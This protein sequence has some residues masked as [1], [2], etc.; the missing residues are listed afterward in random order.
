MPLSYLP[1]YPPEATTTQHAAPSKNSTSVSA[2]RPSS[3]ACI[4]VK[5][6][7][8]KSGRT[9]C[10]SGSPKRQ[11]YSITFGPSGVSISPKYRQPRNGLPSAAIARMVGRKIVFMHSA[12][13]SFV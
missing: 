10:V 1:G 3:T 4:T 7:L 8:F 12:A 13:I 2:R 5:R 11:L 6:S 9:T